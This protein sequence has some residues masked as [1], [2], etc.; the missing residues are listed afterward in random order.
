MTNPLHGFNPFRIIATAPR[1]TLLPHGGAVVSYDVYK[2]NLSF[3]TINMFRNAGYQERTNNPTY[4]HSV[5]VIFDQDRDPRALHYLNALTCIAPSVAARLSAL[6]ESKGHVTLW[7]E[8][9]LEDD[10]EG[11]ETVAYH[12]PL[13][14]EWI[15]ELRELEM[16]AEIPADFTTRVTSRDQ[17][18]EIV[19]P[20]DSLDRA[21]LEVGK[22]YPLGWASRA[23]RQ[24]V[25]S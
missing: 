16:M 7:L 23:A 22:L 1:S 18:E 10:F 20:S 3:E 11:A 24:G 5:L 14:D 13:K 12:A 8:R 25:R 6:H 19:L 21:V 17:R 4:P 9:L 2:T 15:P